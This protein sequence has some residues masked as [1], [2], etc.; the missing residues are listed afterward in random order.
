VE[1]VRRHDVQVLEVLCRHDDDVA[2][3]QTEKVWTDRGDHQLVPVDYVA[4]V[5]ERWQSALPADAAAQE[6]VVVVGRVRIH[7]LNP[8]QVDSI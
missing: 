4:V 7:D 8:K 5:Y 1:V 6:A 3:I 2:A